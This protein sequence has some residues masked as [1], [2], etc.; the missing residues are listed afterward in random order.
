[1]ASI[2]EFSRLSAIL[3][4]D[5]AG[6][7]KNSEIARLQ[8][9]KFGTAATRVGQ[10]LTRGLGLGLT[11]VGGAA[12]KT[13]SEFNKISVQLRSL[14]DRTSFKNLTEQ[15]R[16]LGETTIFTRIQIAEAQKEL[17]K[18]GTSG[19]DIEKILPGVASLAGALDEDLAGA[20]S[21]VKEAL[22]IYQLEA[23]RAQDVTDLFAQAVQSSALT[24]PQ[25]REGLKNIGPILA[26]QNLSIEDSVA[27]LALLSN[28]ALKGSISGTKLRST[29]NKLAKEGFID[30]NVSLELLKNNTLDYAQLLDLLN[31]RSVVVGAIVKDQAEDL[32]DLSLAFNNATGATQ[33]L[34]KEFEG[35]LFYTT[36]QLKNA[37]QQLGIEIGTALTPAVESLRDFMVDLAASFARMDPESKKFVGQVLVAI[38]VIGAMVFIVGQLSI[39][40]AAI[41]PITAAVVVT[42]AGLA[43]AYENATR[44]ARAFK[45]IVDN[46]EVTLNTNQDRI[47]GLDDL[48][49]TQQLKES[50]KVIDDLDNKLSP[51]KE[52]GI[53]YAIALAR[54]NLAEALQDLSGK[55][56]IVAKLQAEAEQALGTDSSASGLAR[57]LKDLEEAKRKL[58]DQRLVALARNDAAEQGLKAEEEN[59]ALAEKTAE[60]QRLKLLDEAKSL[61]NNEKLKKLYERIFKAQQNARINALPANEQEVAKIN[62][63]FDEF[64]KQLVDLGGNTDILETIREELI[65]IANAATDAEAAASLKGLKDG[66]AL[67]TAEGVN[68]EILTINQDIDARI[69]AA[70]EYNNASEQIALLEEERAIRIREA[71]RK[72]DDAIQKSRTDS[73]EAYRSFVSTDLQ[74]EI[75]AIQTQGDLLAQEYA[76]GSEERI[77]IETETARRIK[78]LQEDFQTEQQR[79]ALQN[80]RGINDIAEQVGQSFSKAAFEGENFFETLKKSFLS[81]FQAIVAK[82]VSLIALYALLAILSGGTTA[83]PTSGLG[84]LAQT[85][86]GDSFG[87]FLTAGFSMRSAQGGAGA[88]AFGSRI[89]G[90]DIV[91]SNQM[92]GRQMTRIGG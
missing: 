54:K 19:V 20:A 74:N 73:L 42:L 87:S 37:L 61:A 30:A 33:T 55:N 64:R 86:M 7:M 60:E 25:L 21:S 44:E 43:L 70:E 45:N 66:I 17:A 48:G 39:A 13:A 51:D 46:T 92:S 91:V 49:F 35:E 52:G 12:V 29:F 80:L 5:I 3:T 89:D 38:P 31:S 69:K 32:E 18:L 53:L 15:S 27:L 40:L 24:I 90:G 50:K 47:D 1:M 22:N 11:L 67:L 63:R 82:L 8:L 36:E 81:F 84:K 62:Q 78:Q 23:T 6:F 26:Q 83:A 14:T 65:G 75:R 58:E 28:S 71:Y 34:A 72:S 4:L 77:A 56:G 16:E 85:A 76:R 88:G 68:K 57:R 10:T 9:V 2:T 79:G 41:N 59:A